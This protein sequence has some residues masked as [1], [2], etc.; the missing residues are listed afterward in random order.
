MM[1]F[2]RQMAWSVS[3]FYH[4]TVGTAHWFVPMALARA[5][6]F[7]RGSSVQLCLFGRVLCSHDADLQLR[8]T[9]SAIS[10]LD[11]D[12]STPTLT[13]HFARLEP[14]SSSSG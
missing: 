4:A 5:Q 8:R 11:T 6:L 9:E 1:A 2:F 14:P 13:F 3:G 10:C 12:S 7:N